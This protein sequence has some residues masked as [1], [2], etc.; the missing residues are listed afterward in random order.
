MWLIVKAQ[1]TLSLKRI[2][3][4][5]CNNNQ[6]IYLR[7]GDVIKLGRIAFRIREYR[8]EGMAESTES[9]PVPPYQ[10]THMDLQASRCVPAYAAVSITHNRAGNTEVCRICYSDTHTLANPLLSVCNCTGTLRFIHYNC[11]KAWLATKLATKRQGTILS[12]YL[13]SLECEICK[14]SYPCMVLGYNSLIDSVSVDG[15]HYDL[16]DFE[17]PVKGSY[18][19][20]E[21]FCKDKNFARV[22]HIAQ[23]EPAHP[24]FKMG[25][26]HDSELKISDISVSRVHAQIIMTEKGYKLEDNGSKFG[27]LILLAPGVHEIDPSNGLSLQ[28]SRTTLALTVKPNEAANKNGLGTAAGS[29]ELVHGSPTAAGNS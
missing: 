24:G 22:V 11:L 29:G 15:T 7:R 16:V 5:P 13:K 18:I 8:I 12:Y 1:P 23:T 19:Q 6:E 21:T 25:R 3:H 2:P 17:K 14:F 28:V 20:L 10:D 4:D 26:G 9:G 27:T